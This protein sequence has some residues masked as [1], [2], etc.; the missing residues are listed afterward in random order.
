MDRFIFTRRRA[1]PWRR[2]LAAV[3]GA[4]GLVVLTAVSAGL[5]LLLAKRLNQVSA[6]RA[7]SEDGVASLLRRARASDV[8][9]R[10]FLAAEVAKDACKLAVL[11]QVRHPTQ[12]N[13]AGFY[14]AAVFTMRR[15]DASVLRVTGK[16]RL[17]GDVQEQHAFS[18]D[19]RDGRVVGLALVP[20]RETARRRP[21]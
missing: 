6:T 17:A 10:R 7:A 14:Q 9:E 19:V 2:G 21:G 1:S 8:T 18:C 15:G 12:A 3:V 16:A 4:G 11:A 13:R 20:T 5:G